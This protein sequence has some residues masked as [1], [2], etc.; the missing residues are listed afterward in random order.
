MEEEENGH[1]FEP[2][3][4]RCLLK[5]DLPLVFAMSDL[6]SRRSGLL[7]GSLV[8]ES[9]SL[10]VHWIYDVVELESRHGRV[11]GYHAPGEDSY[12]PKKQAGDQGHVGDQALCLL[13]FLKR[14]G[15]WDA[16]SYLSAW[17]SMWVDYGDYI[18]KATKTTLANLKGGASPAV[19]AAA[20]DELAGPA[21]MAPLLAFLAEADQ[22][23]LIEAAVEQTVLTHRSVATIESAEFL[24]KAAYRLFEGVSLEDCLRD[25]APGWALQAAEKVEA[26]P[27]VEAIGELGSSCPISASLPAVIYLALKYGDDIQSAFIENAMAGGDNCARGLT[28]GMLLGGAHGVEAIPERWRVELVCADELRNF[29]D[30]TT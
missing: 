6:S 17:Q 26:L 3:G 20:S 11:N 15:Q 13:R 25:V 28:L 16:V 27:A 30:T 18:D 2:R 24:A 1:L 7:W 9:L 10:G 4:M 5:A 22:A 23:T 29:L 12:H 21:R 8:A 14:T 19:C